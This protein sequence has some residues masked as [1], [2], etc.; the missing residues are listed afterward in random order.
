MKEYRGGSRT[1]AREV[2]PSATFKEFELHFRGDNEKP[3]MYFKQGKDIT[4][5][6]DH[7]N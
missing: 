1:M 6:S 4:P 2:E 3:L 7:H 5:C